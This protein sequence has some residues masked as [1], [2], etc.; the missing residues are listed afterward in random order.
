MK[1]KLNKNK[2]IKLAEQIG[3]DVPI[4]L[5]KRNTFFNW[6]KKAKY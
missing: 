1:L 4:N 2:V 3:F 6:K 5:E